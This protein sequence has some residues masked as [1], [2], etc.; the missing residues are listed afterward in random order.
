MILTRCKYFYHL[1][2]IL[3]VR[4]AVNPVASNESGDSIDWDKINNRNRSKVDSPIDIKDE[5]NQCPED[6]EAEQIRKAD[7]FIEGLMDKGEVP[8]S[9]TP[10]PDVS[11]K[12]R[13]SVSP[14]P[15][16]TIERKKPAKREATADLVNKLLKA[17]SD[18]GNNSAKN[19]YFMQKLEHE[20]AKFEFEKEAAKRQHDLELKKHADSHALELKKLEYENNRIRLADMKEEMD[21]M[22]KNDAFYEMY[23]SRYRDLLFNVKF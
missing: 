20:A 6:D 15:A 7:E 21:A 4:A 3:L 14:L 12:K 22:D 8:R 9:D 1:K 18:A 19:R 23:N 17:R 13:K 5:D 11:N 2:P 16:D 10:A